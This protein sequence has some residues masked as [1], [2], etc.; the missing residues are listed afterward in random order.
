MVSFNQI[1][2]VTWT[3]VHGQLATGRKT[4]V[5]AT[6]APKVLS[7]AQWLS[8]RAIIDGVWRLTKCFRIF[9]NT[10]IHQIHECSY[11]FS[12]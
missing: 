3:G 7:L 12:G 2:S 8:C 5:L 9:K 4:P 6:P 11:Y 10:H 1:W